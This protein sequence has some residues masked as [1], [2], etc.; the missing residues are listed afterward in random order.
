MNAVRRRLAAAWRL[1]D[2]RRAVA[3][4]SR[5]GR[6]EGFAAVA[7]VVGAQLVIA[8]AGTVAFVVALQRMAG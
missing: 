5:P 6:P 1:W 8:A 3:R 2:A 7:A 4:R